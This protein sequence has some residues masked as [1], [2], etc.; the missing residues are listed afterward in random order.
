MGFQKEDDEAN[1]VFN[2]EAMLRWYQ[3]R[4]MYRNSYMS[5]PP[6]FNMTRNRMS[7]ES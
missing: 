7:S 1:P 6:H 2:R 5:P 3:E 4:K